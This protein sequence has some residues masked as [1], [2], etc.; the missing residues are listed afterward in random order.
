VVLEENQGFTGAIEAGVDAAGAEILIFL[1]NDT[2][3]EERWLETLVTALDQAP[4]EVATVTGRILSW[5]GSLVDFWRGAL[6]FDGHAFQLDFG[7]PLA[8][9]AESGRK[10]ELPFPCGGNMAVRR[11]VWQ[12]LGGFDPTYF[13]YTE[14]VDFG[15][16]AWL[17][18][19]DHLY[20]PE[21]VIHHRSGATGESLGLCRR[22]FLFERNA[23]MTVFKNLEDGLFQRLLPAV[24]WTL[25][26]RTLSL[27]GQNSP[28]GWLLRR[29]SFPPHS[30]RA[31]G[32]ATNESVARRLKRMGL[33]EALR[34][35]CLKAARALAR[36][37]HEQLVVT[38]PRTLEQLRSLQFLLDHLDDLVERRKGVQALRK[39]SDGEFFKR[40]PLL[41]VP[42][43]PGDLELFQKQGFRFLMPEELEVVEK[44]LQEIGE[45]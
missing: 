19:W 29:F 5:D 34:R 41:L 6:T 32:A 3:V 7:R 15:W 31:H 37:E 10:A 22:G 38:D 44:T 13:A 18:G 27:M 14:D 21:A 35:V 25:I 20:E 33:R 28:D 16:R 43:Y 23:F 9:V 2:R 1:N 11:R 17:A 40:F 26:H 12:T 45:L 8:K 36:E 4:P 42:T 24:L 39:R 30:D